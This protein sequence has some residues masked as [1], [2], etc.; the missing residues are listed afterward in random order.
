MAGLHRGA[1]FNSSA[2][3]PFATKQ[4]GKEG[5][6]FHNDPNWAFPA[7]GQIASAKL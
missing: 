4:N 5:Y 1:S 3:S 6:S 2:E 7:A